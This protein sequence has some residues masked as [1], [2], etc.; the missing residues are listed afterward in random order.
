MQQLEVIPA[1]DLINGQC[2]RL[3]QGDFGQRTYYASDPVAVAKQFEAAG[4]RRL[5]MVDLDG[6]RAGQPKHLHILQ[7]VAAETALVIDFSGGIKTDGDLEAVFEAGTGLA[8]VGSVA[9]KDKSLFFSWLQKYGADKI[10]LGVD[11]REE[12]LAVSGWLEQTEIGL[13]EFLEEMTGAG[14]R[15]IFC[16]DIGRDGLLSGPSTALYRRVLAQFPG[17][18][19]IASGGVSSP[20]DLLELAEIGCAG[21]IVGKAIYED[22]GNLA[23]WMPVETLHATSVHPETLHATSVHPE[24]LHATS[25]LAKRIIPCLDIK[26]GRTVKGVHFVNLRDAGDPVELAARYAVQGAD[27]LVFL[28]ITATHEGRK[29]FAEL[30]RRI[31]QAINIPFTVGGGIGSVADVSV[32]LEAGADKVSVNSAA[33]R[34]PLLINELSKEFGSQ[35]IVVAI[36]AKLENGD[37]WVY[38][39]GG[40]LRTELRALDWAKEAQ[41]RGAGEILLTSMDHDGS[42]NGFAIE[43]TKAVSKQLSIPVIASGGAGRMEHFSEVF[44]EGK[45]DAALAASIFHF[46]EILVPDLKRFLFDNG[47]A[48]RV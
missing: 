47:V 18:D 31:A 12:K 1:M 34:N 24:T 30:V 41:E 44:T 38:L 23:K 42:K 45:A 8:A 16:T 36:D 40:R 11:V 26:D 29:T 21:V 10:M 32:L 28:D 27:E 7:K 46:G 6:A 9:V 14:V 43:L 5:H 39:N 19:L 35:C 2:V 17:L 33:V 3:R 37:W 20:A 4:F 48:V 25:L 13:F 15:Q 22:L